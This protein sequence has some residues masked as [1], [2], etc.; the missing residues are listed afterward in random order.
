MGFDR[1]GLHTRG[2]YRTPSGSIPVFL[3]SSG[4]TD[5]LS[6][7]RSATRCFLPARHGYRSCACSTDRALMRMSTGLDRCVVFGW[8]ATWPSTERFYCQMRQREY[9]E[10][11]FLWEKR[12]F[13]IKI[14][15]VQTYGF[16]SPYV[17]YK[18]L[19]IFNIFQEQGQLGKA[20]KPTIEEWVPQVAAFQRS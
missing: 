16:C 14:V 11:S 20:Q 7:Y 9:W 5:K 18:I 15:A 4:R 2:S 17:F 8:M 12:I 13:V 6:P 3:L 10:R 1:S 19:I